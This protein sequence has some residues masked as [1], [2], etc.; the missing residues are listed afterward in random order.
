MCKIISI[1]NNK[2][3]VSKTTTS[4][5][6]ATLLSAKFKVLLKDADPQGSATE[7]LETCDNIPFDFAIANTRSL[8][9]KNGGFDY[10]VIDT[11]PQNT[12]IMQKA[13]DVADFV[14]IPTAPSGLD[15]QG[16][17]SVLDSVEI[18]N[19]YKILFTMASERTKSF[20]KFRNYSLENNVKVFKTFIP[21]KEIIK[22]SFGKIPSS[23]EELSN[24]KMLVKELLIE[25]GVNDNE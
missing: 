12:L 15:M 9:D 22:N 17:V 10:I 16:V 6:L 18:K 19:N 3:G 23:T 1:V 14:I 5:F 21:R 13:I 24:Y 4:V 2:G 20:V 8:G 25:L 7:W 11:P